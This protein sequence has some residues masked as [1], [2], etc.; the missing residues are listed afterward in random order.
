MEYRRAIEL[1]PGYWA[2]Y[3]SLAFLYDAQGR[4]EEAARLLRRV[5]ELRPDNPLGYNDLGLQYHRLGQLDSAAVWYR[6]ATEVN[7]AAT[8]PT[9]LAYRNLGDLAYLQRNYAEAAQTYER[10]L[11]LDSTTSD[12]WAM[13]GFASQLGGD[14]AGAERAFR[15]MLALDEQALE[16]NP[17]DEDALVGVAIGYARTERPAR[18]QEALQHLADLPQKEPGTLLDMATAYELLNDRPSALHFLGEGIEKGLTRAR[19]EDSPLLDALRTDPR[20][21]Q[22]IRDRGL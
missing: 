13:L 18:A 3:G 17:N 1:K 22:L 6:R 21:R 4:H 10:A 7:P 5:I 11:R 9:A 8:G 14:A 12:T 15:R 2:Y 16:V 20:Y 19:I